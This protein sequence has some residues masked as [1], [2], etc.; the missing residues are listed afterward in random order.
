MAQLLKEALLFNQPRCGCGRAARRSI[1]G[2][3]AQPGNRRVGVEAAQL[4]V[5]RGKME[6]R[7]EDWKF[8]WVVDFPLM[9]YDEDAKRYLATHHP[10]TAPA[11]SPCVIRR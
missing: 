10:F 9:T 1:I 11:V 5:K 6:I 8:L 4:L 7:H 3:T 2:W